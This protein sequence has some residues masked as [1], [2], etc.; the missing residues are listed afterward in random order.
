[1]MTLIDMVRLYEGEYEGV[2]IGEGLFDDAG[3][4]IGIGVPIGAYDSKDGGGTD[5]DV[6]IGCAIRLP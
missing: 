5:G 1:M 4:D 6:V 3:I 2:E